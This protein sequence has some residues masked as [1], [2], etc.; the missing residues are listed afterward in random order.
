MKKLISFLA[1]AIT[2]LGIISISACSKTDAQADKNV[3]PADNSS[4]SVT[5]E[6]TGDDFSAQP[7][8][9]K[10]IEVVYPGS[11][12]VTLDSNATTGFSWNEQPQ[13]S[14][15]GIVTQYDHNYVAP[16]ATG[17]VGAAGKEVWT[18]KPQKTGAVTISFEY[19]RPWEGGEKAVR[20]VQLTINIKKET[21]LRIHKGRLFTCP[22]CFSPQYQV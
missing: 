14:D 5:W 4:K 10:T 6:V 21:E 20:T 11:V 18:F 17:V 13:I 22:F 3:P 19:S 15:T 9:I 12:V 8:I 1:I 2:L 16:T 7:N